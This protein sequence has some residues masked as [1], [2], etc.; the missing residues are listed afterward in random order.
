[1]SLQIDKILDLV[2]A[3]GASDLHLSVH[4]PPVVR[5]SGKLRALNTPP[6]TGEDTLALMKSITS[7]RA[8]QELAETGGADPIAEAKSRARNRWRRAV[9]M[10]HAN[11]AFKGKHELD[12]LEGDE[13][14]HHSASH[15]GGP[16]T[17]L[18][19]TSGPSSAS[20]KGRRGRRGTITLET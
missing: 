13:A 14:D 19:K 20:K 3:K 18:K 5:L 17:L 16:S 8:Q 1:M 12:A 4:S 10:V 7:N 11:N 9:N 15:H 2:V 6:L